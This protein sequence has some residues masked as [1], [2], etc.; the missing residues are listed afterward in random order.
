MWN[1]SFLFPSVLVLFTLLIFYF[2]RPRLSIRINR[3][4][5]AMLVLELFIIAADILSSVADEDY[6]DLTVGTLYFLNTLFFVLYFARAYG[7]FRF[8]A[9][10]LKLTDRRAAVVALI[11]FIFC[12]IVALSSRATGL[13]YRIT[14]AGYVRGPW[15]DLLFYEYLVYILAA[16][17]LVF[18][19]RRAMKPRD[20]AACV[21]YELAL[22]TGTVVRR[23]APR[24]LVMNTFALV[25]VLIIYL[26]FENPDRYLSERGNAFNMRGFVIVL[27]ELAR[28]SDHHI[29]AFVMKNYTHERSIYGGTQTDRAIAQ[30][31]GYLRES[32]PSCMPFYLRGGRFALLGPERLD[33][34]AIRAAIADRFERQWFTELGTMF[35]QVGF[36]ELRTQP[37]LDTADRIVNNLTIAL[38]LVGRPDADAPRNLVMDAEGIR[39]LDEEVDIL[40]TLTGAIERGDVE[41]FLQPVFDSRARRLVAAEA[42]CRIRDDTGRILPP[43]LFIPVAERNG[44]I[45]RLGDLVFQKTCAFV[46]DHDVDAMGL[47]WVNVNLS[48]IQCLRRDLVKRLTDILALYGLPAERVHLEITE[49]SIVDYAMMEAQIDGLREAGFRIVLDDYGSGYSNLTRVKHYPFVDIKLDM[50]VVWDY[51]QTRDSLLPHVVTA[52]KE[53]GFTITAEGIETPGMADALAALGCDYLQGYLFDEPLPIEAFVEKYQ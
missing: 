4:F 8:T 45:D 12:E 27:D 23:L 32:F 38:E 43:G 47:R 14:G 18:V 22:L 2:T 53:L 25:G 37:R 7:F 40:R 46:H 1:Y 9:D 3:T 16:L 24:L 41:V 48:P 17:V 33:W 39:K 11:P 26:A 31:N 50:E 5:L 42:L 51:C 19:K 21:G 35:L 52:F 13:I 36:A 49:Q 44:L 20:A 10:V 6:T 29:L 15:Y 30:I 28:R 34:E